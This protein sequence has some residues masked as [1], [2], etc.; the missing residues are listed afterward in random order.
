MENRQFVA[1]MWKMGRF[2]SGKRMEN[3]RIHAKFSLCLP[4]ALHNGVYTRG[5]DKEKFFEPWKTMWKMLQ[6]HVFSHFI[7]CFD[8][9]E[10]CETGK[11][12]TLQINI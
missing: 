8:S 1:E 12:Y 9:V 4:Y 3:R 6:N 10:N 5:K 11:Y 7:A 2:D